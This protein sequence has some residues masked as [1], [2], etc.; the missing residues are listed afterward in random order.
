MCVRSVSSGTV[1]DSLCQLFQVLRVRYKLVNLYS[2]F[3]VCFM[4]HFY[5]HTHTAVHS[6][7]NLAKKDFFSELLQRVMFVYC[8]SEGDF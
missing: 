3:L 5:A 2:N 8:E 6:S 4:D 1:R 7:K